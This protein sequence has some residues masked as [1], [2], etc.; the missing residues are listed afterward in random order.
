[1]RVLAC[2]VCVDARVLVCCVLVWCASDAVQSH[3][4]AACV[5]RVDRECDESSE[6]EH[7]IQD[8]VQK[9]HQLL[10]AWYARCICMHTLDRIYVCIV[11]SDVQHTAACLRLSMCVF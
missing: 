6:H 5:E 7:F 2:C 9:S 3:I 11:H 8:H 1:M 10:L 4:A